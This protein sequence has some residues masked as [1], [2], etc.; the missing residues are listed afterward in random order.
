L[1][2]DSEQP[3]Q[4]ER[5]VSDNPR[6][7]PPPPPPPQQQQQQ[8]PQSMWQGPYQA[9]PT[10][11]PTPTVQ[12]PSAFWP[13]TIISFVCSFFIGGVAMYFSSQVGTKWR[14]GDVA[15]ARKA[16]QT[17]Q[18]IGI[19]GIVLGVLFFFIELVAAASADTS[20]Y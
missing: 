19:I 7:Y 15:G 9:Q 13:L 18:I 1:K 3:I 16:S 20:G 5:K 2:T 11:T 10:P 12:E 17:A 6:R 8:P 4:K 14:A